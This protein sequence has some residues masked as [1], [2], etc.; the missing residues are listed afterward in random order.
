[1]EYSSAS[2]SF[3]KDAIITSEPRVQKN[4]LTSQEIWFF[5]ACPRT[6]S[7]K[8]SNDSNSISRSSSW[9]KSSSRKLCSR[10][11]RSWIFSI[12]Q[13][14]ESQKK[15]S[16]QIQT[17][18]TML[19]TMMSISASRLLSSTKNGIQPKRIIENLIDTASSPCTTIHGH[20]MPIE[21]QNFSELSSRITVIKTLEMRYYRILV[22][23]WILMHPTRQ[24]LTAF[25]VRPISQSRSGENIS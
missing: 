15:T 14:I 13:T 8:W 24:P 22:T 16:F 19:S 1:M 17:S 12:R 9:R 5:I 23:F 11:L 2:W 6:N 25:L 3:H 20:S 21:R 10:W 18:I 4:S 7:A